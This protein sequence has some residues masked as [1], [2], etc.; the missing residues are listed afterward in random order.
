MQLLLG[1]LANA[2]E[3][4]WG[5]HVVIVKVDEVHLVYFDAVRLSDRH[6]KYVGRVLGE[7]QW[8]IPSGKRARP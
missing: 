8:K 6:A 7:G 1:N 3:E 2:V 4:C 5:D